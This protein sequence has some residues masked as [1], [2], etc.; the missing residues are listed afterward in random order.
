M[1]LVVPSL[2]D[3][4]PYNKKRIK[5]NPPVNAKQF[6]FPLKKKLGETFFQPLSVPLGGSK[7][8]HFQYIIKFS[9][10]VSPRE[11]KQRNE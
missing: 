10:I 3:T 7:I 4:E 5:Q 11:H 1:N 2:C 8:G 9:L 6:S